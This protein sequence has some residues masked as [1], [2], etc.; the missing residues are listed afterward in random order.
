MPIIYR[1][2]CTLYTFFVY[3]M[4]NAIKVSI[5]DGMD[6]SLTLTLFDVVGPSI[7]SPLQLMLMLL[8]LA[9]SVSKHL[10]RETHDQAETPQDPSPDFRDS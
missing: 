4:Q 2:F 10:S 5:S 6:S 7:S 8:T 1:I 3:F 9:A